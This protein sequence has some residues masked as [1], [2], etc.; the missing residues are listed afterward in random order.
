MGMPAATITSMTAHGGTVILGFPQ[1]LI[2][3]MPAS[4]ITDMHVCPMVTGIVP[5]VGG[6]FV[7]GAMT[8]LTGMMPQ[9]RVTDQ[10]V[11]VGPPDICVMGAE[12]VLVGEA[13]AGGAGGAMGGISAMGASVPMQSQAAQTS[14]QSSS[15]Q[16]PNGTIKTSAPPGG[17]LPAIPLSS[18]GFPTLPAD[19]TPNFATAQP[20]DVPPGTTL[21]RAY[22]NLSPSTGGYWSPNPPTSE[23]QWRN[24]NA[25]G[26]W[27]SGA[28]LAIAQV[29]AGGLKAW[30]GA[31]SQQA[32]MAGGGTQLWSP[33][34]SVLPSQLAP[35]PWATASQLAGE[36]AQQAAKGA[37]QLAN[38]AQQAAGQAEQQAKL[39]EQ[40]AG[41]GAQLVAQA[42]QKAQ[43]A[44]NLAHQAAQQC[45][46][47]AQQAVQQSRQSVQ[48]AEQQVLQ[49]VGPAKAVAQQALTQAKQQAQQVEQQGQQA[50]QRAQ[51][52]AQLAQQAATQAAKSAQTA[53]Q[54]AAQQSMPKGL[55]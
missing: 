26:G 48:Q 18:P 37:T 7:L 30:M 33:P 32:G 54:N 23:D 14:S 46:Q 24:D 41:Q 29:P 55:L 47:Q 42:A 12:T 4:R 3:F 36:A 50:S 38:A 49:A 1:V 21:Y 53:G 11:C 20:V 27:N 10:L 9:S 51:Q 5:H 15:E 2:N 17:S 31:A 43:Q 28:L 39:A 6:P 8:V 44:A 40:A 13:G 34:G 52:Q 45:E 35:A 25:V 19:E 16:Q 22:G